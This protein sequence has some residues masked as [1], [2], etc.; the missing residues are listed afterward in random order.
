[1]STPDTKDSATV[2]SLRDVRVD[3]AR[4]DAPVLRDVTLEIG[5]HESVCLIGRSGSGKSTLLRAAAGLLPVAAGTTHTTNHTVMGFQ[6]SRLLPWLRVWK[7]VTLGLDLSGTAARGTA[8]N[9]LAEVQLEN[10]MDVW[11][12]ELSGGQ[13]QRVALARALVRTPRFL[14]LDEPFGA[15]DSL[16]RMDMQDL[17]DQLRTEQGWALLMV[18]HD[19]AEAVRL[20]DRILVLANGVITRE[21]HIDRSHLDARHRP[22][23]YAALEDEVRT[24]LA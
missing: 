4:P 2:L 23:G 11:P 16:T 9:A 18:T 19:I 22:A 24:A 14:M 21:F 3:F 13:L 10:K 12:N 8:R 20:S 15:L 1:M 17:L 5:A 7:N 6:D